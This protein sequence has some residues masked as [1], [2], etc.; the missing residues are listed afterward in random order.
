MIKHLLLIS[1]LLFTGFSYAQKKKK[2]SVEQPKTQLEEAKLSG[3]K[4]RSVGPALTSGR[5]SDIA[6]NPNNFSEYY[7]A[8]ASGGVWKTTNAGNTFK[9]IFDDQGSYSIGCVT[10]DPGN[11][12]VIWVG[13]GENNGQRSVAYGDGVYKSIDGGKSWEHMGLK[14]SEHIGNILVNPYDSKTVFVSAIGPL[15]SAGDDRGLYKTTDGGKTWRNVL[16]IDQYT[17]VNEVRIDPSNPDVMYASAFQRAR[18]VYTYLGGGPGSGIYKSKDGGETWNK[19]NKGLPEV[20]LGRIGLAISPADPEIIYAIVEAA[21]G[22]GGVFASTNRGASWE[23]RGKYSTSGNYYQ[24]I[25]PDPVDP[26]TIYAMDTWMHVSRDGGRSFQKVGEDA[27]HVD[28]HCLWIN[29]NNTAHLLAGCDGGIYETWD[30]GRN[31]DYKQNLPVTQFYKVALDNAEP[32]YNIYGGTQDNFSQAG[33]SR[34]IS[35]NGPNNFDWIITH[36]GDGFESQVDPGNPDIVYAQSQYGVLVRF[37][38]KSGEEKGIQ[39]KER[40]GENAYRWN[41]DAPL[42]VSNHQPTRLYFAANKLF[43]SDDRGDSWQVISEDLTRQLDRNKLPIMGKIWSVDAVA[44][45]QSTSPYGTIVAFS[46]SP[47][48]ENLLF[49]GTDDGLVQITEDGGKSWTKIDN[50]PGVPSR[51]Y[52]NALFASKHDEN[53]VYA[54]FNHHKYGDFKPYVFRSADK[55]KTWTSI[56][57]NLPKRGS[58]YSF[59]E[60]FVDPNLIFVGTEFGVFF[61][62]TR[63]K[64]WKQIK[65]GVPT[66]AV[67]DLA[68]HPKH[69]DLVLGT[70]GRGFYVLDDYSSLRNISATLTKEA[71]LYSVRDALSFEASY[72]LGLPMKSFQGDNFFIGENLGAEAIFTWY[73]KEDIK[74]KKEFRKEVEKETT[75]DTYPTYD[76]LKAEATETGTTL[77]FTVKN[78]EGEIVRKLFSKPKAG[79]KRMNWDLRYA[80]KGPVDL[81]KPSFYNPWADKNEGTLVPPGDYSVTLSKLTNGEEAQLADPVK[82]KIIALNK[83]TFSAE[84][85]VALAE[86]QDKVRQLNGRL[87]SAGKAI[88]DLKKE[89]RHMKVAINETPTSQAELVKEYDAINA[90]IREIQIVLN[91][92]GI[93]G[94]LDI[95]RPPSVND[96]VGYLEY[97][98][99]HSTAK[100]TQTHLDSYA[101][102][103]EEF[104][105]AYEKLKNLLDVRVEAFR[106]KLKESGAPYTPGNLYFLD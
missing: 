30:G 21:D 5:I 60:D 88:S 13:T 69:T 48:N 31:W 35:G 96:R 93:A 39:P 37:D 40:K 53:V 61:S 38:K 7:V 47:L 50:I 74:T 68:I 55:G 100:P 78:S 3:L 83:A 33:P 4:F 101:I 79:L 105:P 106:K 22:K 58:T 46:E 29:P 10:M 9:P 95:G 66:I 54:C 15:W 84:D 1:A 56:S 27:K 67:R 87:G 24:E 59:E 97:E 17:G 98:Q 43:K 32:F 82:F 65:A 72:P 104:E 26:N 64:E 41:W 85:K 103:K 51:T 76:E 20:D 49:V 92:D 70:F 18:H 42:A 77:L 90:T 81:S 36:G 80:P 19:I 99:G 2:S 62:D 34:T 12:N 52:V 102:A 57:S 63:G 28:N 11:P 16:S 23:R 75:N 73:L 44:K 25:V 91:G 8:S 71:N 94:K 45:N 86:F 14:N 89:L 6:V